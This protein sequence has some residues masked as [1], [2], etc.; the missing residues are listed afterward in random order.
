[1]NITVDVII[2][3]GFKALEAVGALSVFKYANA[4]LK[5]RGRQGDT[6]SSS[7][8]CPSGR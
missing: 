6:T 4:H 7:R 8:P 5:R 1:M 3:P 2:Y